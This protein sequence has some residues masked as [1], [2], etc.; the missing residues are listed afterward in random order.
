MSHRAHGRRG[1]RGRRGRPARTRRATRRPLVVAVE[2]PCPP[3]KP[4]VTWRTRGRKLY[5]QIR[6][7]LIA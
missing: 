1:R 6:D 3:V 7:Y 5:I 4:V 2:L